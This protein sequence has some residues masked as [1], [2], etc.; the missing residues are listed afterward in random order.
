MAK[1]Y[2]LD[3]LLRVREIRKD[4][5][6]KNLTQAQKLLKEAE[7][8][9]AKAKQELEDY[10]LFVISETNRLYNQILKKSIKKNSVDALH[11]AVKELQNKIFEYEKRVEDAIVMCQKA[12]ENL[13]KRREELAQAKRNIDKIESLKDKWREEVKKEEELQSDLEMEDFRVK[14]LE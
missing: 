3:D 2:E 13:E 14:N 1:K 10:K 5:A 9:L 7:Q 6:E 12:K 4:R 11:A 8:A